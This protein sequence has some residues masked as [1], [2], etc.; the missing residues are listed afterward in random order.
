MYPNDLLVDVGSAQFTDEGV[1][2][3]GALKNLT[4]L[5][6]RSNALADQSIKHLK[7]LKRLQH[8]EVTVPTV[9]D[10]DV[11]ILASFRE[12]EI[13]ASKSGTQQPA[14]GDVRNHPRLK[15]AFINGSRL[16]TDEVVKVIYTIPNLRYL[17]IG[18]NESLQHLVNQALARRRASRY[19]FTPAKDGKYELLVEVHSNAD[20]VVSASLFVMANGD[21]EETIRRH[22]L[23]ALANFPQRKLP[24]II[25]EELAKELDRL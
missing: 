22:C 24:S 18:G 8:L 1:R 7:D 25:N 14:T 9:N 15:S 2:H 3:L 23:N 5:W 10:R 21:K 12:L 16:S 19:K 20:D 17:D 6:L 13:L 11:M 4:R